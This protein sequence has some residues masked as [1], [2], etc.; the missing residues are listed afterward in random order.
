MLLKITDGQALDERRLMDVYAESNLENADFFCPEE[1]DKE[2]AV[3]MVESGFLDFLKNEF[4]KEP[5][6]I[7][8]VL[9]EGGVWVSALRICRIPEGP[10]YL[11]ALETRPDRRRQGYGVRLLSEVLDAMK[12][13][14]PFRLCDCVGKKNAASLKAHEKC[15]FRIVSSRAT[16]T[17]IRRRMT[18]ISGWNT[19]MKGRDG[20]EQQKHQ[21]GAGPVWCFY[22]AISRA[23]GSRGRWGPGAGPGPGSSHRRC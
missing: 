4:F 11:E 22:Y 6:A 2:A 21:A 20:F 18:G 7:C 3:R 5:E 19:A 8:W 9:E 10:Y 1:P 15:G 13:E 12:A 16:I 17:C 14:G 23:W